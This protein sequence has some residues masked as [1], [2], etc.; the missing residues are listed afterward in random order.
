MTIPWYKSWAQ[1]SFIALEWER[2]IICQAHPFMDPLNCTPDP[3]Y[4]PELF[5][6]ISTAAVF[7]LR[8]PPPSQAPQLL[9]G[10]LY[11]TK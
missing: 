5:I 4:V 3:S 11:T 10:W 6:W 7:T 8:G 9:Q 2:T 1:I